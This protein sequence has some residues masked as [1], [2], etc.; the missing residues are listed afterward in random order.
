LLAGAAA[1]GQ[2]PQEAAPAKP[3]ADTLA[4]QPSKTEAEP[5]TEV[6]VQD[7][8][9]TFK[10]RVNLVQALVIVRSNA[11]TPV[12]GLHKEDFQSDFSSVTQRPQESEFAWPWFGNWCS[13]TG[14]NWPALHCAY[15][16]PGVFAL[17]RAMSGIIS[18]IIELAPI[19]L[20][21]AT[22]IVTL[23]AVLATCLPALRATR[24]DPMVA[25]RSE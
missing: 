6:S 12:E 18:G 24:V 5:K 9:N 7:T 20:I 4:S 14:S 3:A 19:T 8:G 11:G 16:L 22:A 21:L 2:A 13:E 17:R 10:L 1:R 23:T 15:G 25:M